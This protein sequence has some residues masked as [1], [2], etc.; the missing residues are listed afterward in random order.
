MKKIFLLL[1]GLG[2]L[3]AQA[4]RHTIDLSGQ[5]RLSLDN[6]ENYQGIVSL[7]GTTDTNGKGNPLVD[8]TETTHLSRKHSYVGPAWYTRTVEIPENWVGY[9][10]VLTLERTKPSQI[11]IDGTFAGGSDNISTPQQFDLT[12]HLKDSGTHTIAIKIDN[13]TGVPQELYESSHAYTESTQTNW[14]GI[15]GEMSLEAREP[16]HLADVRIYP[17]A[18][19]RVATVRFRIIHNNRLKAPKVR[20]SAESWNSTPSHSVPPLEMELTPGEDEY[21]V[22]YPMGPDALLWSEFDPAMYHLKVELVGLDEIE[23]DF[24]LRDFSTDGTQFTINGIKTFLRGKHDACVWPLTAHTPMDVESWRRYMQIC[25]DYGINHIRFHSWC[26]PDAAFT[27][28]DIEGLYLQPEL[29]FWGSL[30]GDNPQLVDFLRCEGE[31]IQFAYGNHPSFVMFALGNEFWG[32]PNTW[33]YLKDDF[34]AIDDRRLYAYGSN[35][36][37]GYNGHLEGEDYLTTCRIGGEAWGEY[38]TH[39]RGSFSFA[40]AYDGGLINHEY[41]NT[42]TNFEG[43]IK[44]C[45]VPVISHETGQ[46]QVYPN[47]NEIEKYTGVLTPCNMEVFRQRLRDAGMGSQAEDF[48]RASGALSALLYKADTEMCLRTPGLGGFQLLDLQD[49]PGQGS[50]YVGMLDA[51]MDSKGLITPTL[52]RQHCDRVVPLLIIEKYCWEADEPIAASIKIANYSGA[53]LKN[54]KVD[55]RLSN[56]HGRVIDRGSLSFANGG[57][58]LIEAGTIKPRVGAVD[59]AARLTLELEADGYN[60]SYPLWVFPEA[61]DDENFQGNVIIA[62]TLDEA[63]INLL[64]LGEKVLL[65]PNANT[66]PENTIP[67]LFQTDYWNYRMFRTIC[68]NANKEVSPGTMGLLIDTKHPIFENFPTE[69]HSNWQWFPIAKASFPLVL[70]GAPHGLKPIVQTIDNVE[71]NHRLGLVWEAA[72]GQGR[73]LVCMADLYEANGPEGAQLFE[74]MLRYMNSPKFTP[75]IQLTKV[76]LQRIFTSSASQDQIKSLHNIS[77]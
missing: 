18:K 16:V 15:I 50:A 48:F 7:P 4:E 55:W 11:Y 1:M 14:N 19:N 63:T 34:R 35:N 38:N 65:M 69:S 58:G 33:R 53:Q 61:N 46:Y 49:Y 56:S 76:D 10:I 66:K 21:V 36:S 30:S 43:A 24:G 64:S 8:R 70:D 5:W 75:S 37:L 25:K 54:N 31:D 62:D 20:L 40:D 28:A 3:G 72:V 17:D 47:Y 74:A 6:I 71:R 51:F 42:V 12:P 29:P 27:A 32:D 9:D 44:D 2:A 77:Y 13:S 41:P 68:E 59:K 26:P 45:P 23:Q 39:T 22:K 73:L 67:G 52:W 60:N 57:I